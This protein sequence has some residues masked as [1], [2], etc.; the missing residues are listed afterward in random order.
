MVGANEVV[1]DQVDGVEV[2]LDDSNAT[3]IDWL[4][5]HNLVQDWVVGEVLEGDVVERELEDVVDLPRRDSGAHQRRVEERD[6]LD[7]ARHVDDDTRAEV[8]CAQ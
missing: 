6:L 4:A 1:D 3:H 5:A 2:R 8:V 7:V